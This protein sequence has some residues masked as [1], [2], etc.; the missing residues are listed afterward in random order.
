GELAGIVNSVP[1]RIS[2]SGHTDIRPYVKLNYSNWELS[3]DRANAARRALIMGG[4]PGEKV[5]RVVGLASS[6]LLDSQAPDSPL[7]RR[8]SIIVMNKRTEDAISQE[9]GALFSVQDPARS[10][11]PVAEG[12]SESMPVAEAQPVASVSTP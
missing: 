10:G 8:I 11:Q 4:L 9:N 5:G 2:V 12:P 3:A 6:V 7:N 1:N